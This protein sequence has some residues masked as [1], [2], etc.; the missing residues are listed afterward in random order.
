[1]EC[2]RGALALSR[3]HGLIDYERESMGFLGFLMY[4]WPVKADAEQ[5]FEDGIARAREL[6]DRVLEGSVLAS[7]ALHLAMH[8]QPY[9]AS[10]MMV[11]AERI[12]SET[13]DLTAIGM[14]RFT[15]SVTERWIG[16]PARSLELTDGLIEA[17]RS[18]SYELI[19]TYLI[20]MRGV[21]LAEVGR[22]EEALEILRH[23]VDICEKL[24][25]N[26]RLGVLYN[27]LGYCY[28]EIHQPR[29]AWEFNLKSE[30]LARRLMKENP[31]GVRQFAEIAAQANVNLMENLFDQGKVDAAWERMQSLRKES[32]SE[33]FDMF[34]HQWE[35]R[36][37]YLGAQILIH[38]NHVDEAEVLI[39]RN[40]EKVR[41]QHAR[42]REGGFLR[43]LGEVRM[44]RGERENAIGDLR[45]GIVILEEVGN[46][47]QL[48]Q[49]RSALAAAFDQSGRSSEAREQWC[50]AAE[51]IQQVAGGLSGPELKEG[52]LA[53]D[54]IRGILSNA[55]S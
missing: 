53:A 4:L 21:A 52:F 6:E 10:Q 35:S 19:V 1:V 43:L 8:G 3:Q 17:L 30:A 7:S 50:A 34:R 33:D 39:R 11:E 31:M 2:A 49:A 27:T 24:G 42:K 15:R 38:R 18:M 55:R 26:I 48:W 23:R 29:K 12:A 20:G 9:R 28:S 16:R 14:T 22:I 37:D 41:E 45:E 47:R 32:R 44:K 40:L 46:P 36:M 13:E 25:V 54:P 51:V 5:I